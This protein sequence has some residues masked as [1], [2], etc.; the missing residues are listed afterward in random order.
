MSSNQ[1]QEMLVAIQ[2]MDM[3]HMLAAYSIRFCALSSQQ[4]NHKE[5]LM[6]A[7]K[8]IGYVKNIFMFD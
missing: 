4:Y 6:S 5:A 1:R 3:R 2:S 8:A 7:K